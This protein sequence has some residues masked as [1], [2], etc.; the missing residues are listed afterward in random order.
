[1]FNYSAK[2]KFHFLRYLHAALLCKRKY[3]KLDFLENVLKY[4]F[5]LTTVIF[6][7][8]FLNNQRVGFKKKAHFRSL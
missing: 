3:E 8:I 2:T 7:L 5:I 6:Q 4:N 1:M